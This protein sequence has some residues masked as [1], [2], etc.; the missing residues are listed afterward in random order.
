MEREFMS[1]RNIVVELSQVSVKI[2]DTYI[3]SNI[4][5]TLR[6]GEN[7]AILGHN[8][9]GETTFLSLVRGDIWPS[10]QC[11]RRLYHLNGKPQQGPIGFHEKT[12][13]VYYGPS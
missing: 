4:D 7:W 13:A 11:G 8:G 2:G 12:G 9:A 1:S 3:L 5:W 6:S 10:P